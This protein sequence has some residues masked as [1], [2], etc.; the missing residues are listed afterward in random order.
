MSSVIVSTISFEIPNWF[1]D[2]DKEHTLQLVDQ[3][4]TFEGDFLAKQH[5]LVLMDVYTDIRIG[6]S[7]QA[8]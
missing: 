8:A 5:K 3:D 2:E 7:G 4:L 6:S 1:T